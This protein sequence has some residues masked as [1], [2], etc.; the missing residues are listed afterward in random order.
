MKSNERT[1]D[2]G[3]SMWILTAQIV[4]RIMIVRHINTHAE[5]KYVLVL[6]LSKTKGRSISI[7]LVFDKVRKDA[8]ISRVTY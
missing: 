3:K 2:A 4:I 5:L 8:V 1:I 6:V 7:I